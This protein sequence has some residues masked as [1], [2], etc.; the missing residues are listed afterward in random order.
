MRATTKNVKANATES[1][2]VKATMNY[3]HL[4]STQKFDAIARLGRTCQRF[5]KATEIATDYLVTTEK[6]IIT[7]HWVKELQGMKGLNPIT[8]KTFN[9]PSFLVQV[10]TFI[11]MDNMAT[12]VECKAI[13]E[14]SDEIANALCKLH[15]QEVQEA[16]HATDLSPITRTKSSNDEADNGN[17][18]Q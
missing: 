6:H 17:E 18:E 1:K 11:N 10:V 8:L 12:M 5:V 9:I 3:S 16:L 13:K 7:L 2:E 15:A 14:T 4:T